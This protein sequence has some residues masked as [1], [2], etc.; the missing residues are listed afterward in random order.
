MCL[1][2]KA[3]L[4][5]FNRSSIIHLYLEYNICT[6]GHLQLFYLKASFLKNLI[7]FFYYKTFCNVSKEQRKNIEKC[8]SASCNSKGKSSV[9]SNNR[10]KAVSRKND[11]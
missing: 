6:N 10:R 9:C 3:N 1:V 11:A 7:K 2:I 4:T 8:V 5:I